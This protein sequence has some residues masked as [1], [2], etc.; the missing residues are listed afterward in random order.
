[1]SALPSVPFVSIDSA[2]V[3]VD[4]PVSTD[5][6]TDIAIDLNYLKNGVDLAGGKSIAIITTP[7][8]GT[9]TVPAGITTAV[10]EMV[11][12][13]GGGAWTVSNPL[14]GGGSGAYQV[15][16]LTGL[17]PGALM[18]LN[19]GAGGPG[20]TAGSTPGA[21]GTRTW[22]GTTGTYADLGTGGNIAAAPG[23]GGV[24]V[25]GATYMGIDGE[26]S[27]VSGATQSTGGRPPWLRTTTKALTGQL[28]P[29]G[30]AGPAGLPYGGGGSGG[31][32]TLGGGG[33]NG[34]AGANGIIV[35]HY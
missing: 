23:A 24:S 32:N 33:A 13:G 6:M 27:P 16:W 4:A 35:I 10:V 28:T 21:S 9:W 15:Y 3:A 18:N 14:F 11:G 8:A 2:R 31:D 20:G 30:S 26:G 1:M 19:V 25:R 12:G 7:G 29:A 5:L 17:I 34:G 22:F